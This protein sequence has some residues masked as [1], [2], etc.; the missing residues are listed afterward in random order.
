[1]N[2][3]YTQI[4]GGHRLLAEATVA[5]GPITG[6]HGGMEMQFLELFTYD[7]RSCQFEMGN[8]KSDI[9]QQA[10]LNHTAVF[11]F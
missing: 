8:D 7:I 9:S 5:R 3:D 2:G 1:M 4:S 10:L 6:S 11:Y